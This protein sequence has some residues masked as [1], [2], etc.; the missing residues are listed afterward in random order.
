MAGSGDNSRRIP[1]C[2]AEGLGENYQIV[3]N[4]HMK[5][6]VLFYEK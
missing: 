3:K 5:E 6:I 1:L 2:P 4:S